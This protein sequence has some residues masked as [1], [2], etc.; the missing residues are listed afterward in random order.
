MYTLSQLQEEDAEKFDHNMPGNIVAYSLMLDI[1]MAHSSSSSSSHAAYPTAPTLVALAPVALAPVACTE[2][3]NISCTDSKSTDE[4]GEGDESGEGDEGE[5][6]R[7]PEG[8]YIIDIDY[9]FETSL[10]TDQKLSVMSSYFKSYMLRDVVYAANNK[11]IPLISIKQ[12][13]YANVNAD[14]HWHYSPYI[15]YRE[16]RIWDVVG[17]QFLKNRALADTVAETERRK[18]RDEEFKAIVSSMM[19]HSRSGSTSEPAG[20]VIAGES[21]S[22]AMDG[23]CVHDGTIVE[24]YPVNMPEKMAKAEINGF[25]QKCSDIWYAGHAP[26]HFCTVHIGKDR[27]CVRPDNNNCAIFHLGEFKTYDDVFMAMDAVGPNRVL[28][29]GKEIFMDLSAFR[30][31][32]AG[33]VF[34]PSYKELKMSDGKPYKESAVV[35]E[36]YGRC[37]SRGFMLFNCELKDPPATN[38]A[39]IGDRLFNLG[40]RFTTQRPRYGEKNALKLET[41]RYGC[42]AVNQGLPQ[43]HRADNSFETLDMEQL[44][45]VVEKGG[46]Y[47]FM[48]AFSPRTLSE[49]KMINI[50]GVDNVA[51]AG[52]YADVFKMFRNCA[53]RK[54]C[55]SCRNP[56]NLSRIL[57]YR[58]DIA[59][60]THDDVPLVHNEIMTFMSR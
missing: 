55:L 22:C 15:R 39:G 20:F 2:N 40:M 33:A 37:L 17:K 59:N 23:S 47:S 48:E 26:S 51:S 11:K 57:S 10:K 13:A 45:S 53:T 8:E 46:C 30:S 1:D 35:L 5:Q 25:V 31:F 43:V 29:D 60:M 49:T 6:Q 21:L 50:W 4:G 24:M 14:G 42:R 52:H 3:I 19:V 38:Y 16:N 12:Y 36:Q 28:C 27:V 34:V 32:K 9:M 58:I 41:S 56:S 54:K 44:L 7:A 18:L